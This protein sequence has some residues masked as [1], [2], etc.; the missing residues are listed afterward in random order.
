MCLGQVNYANR[1]VIIAFLF[2]MKN[3]F[4][5]HILYEKG[6]HMKL[7]NRIKINGSCITL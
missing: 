7:K 1:L 6:V 2:F 4:S 5:K 3:Y